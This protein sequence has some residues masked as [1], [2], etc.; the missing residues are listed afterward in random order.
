MSLNKQTCPIW[1]EP[2]HLRDILIAGQIRGTNRSG[3]EFLLKRDG[4]ALLQDLTERQKV[5]LSYWIY[6]YNFQH[7][8]INTYGNKEKL[9]WV[10][11]LLELDEAWV[12]D[13]RDCTPSALDRMLTWL[14]ELIR[15]DNAGE[16]ITR[17]LQMA[18][19][20]CRNSQ[21][22]DELVRHSMQQG[23]TGS[24]DPNFPSSRTDT[25]NLAGRLYVEERTRKLGQERQGFVARWFDCSMDPMH[26]EGIAPAIRDAGYKSRQIN[27]EGFTG[28]VVDEILAEI[29]KSKFVVADFT[30]CGKCTACKKCKHI[31]ARGGVYFEAGFALGL[32]KTVF[33]TCHKDRAEAVHFDV[34]HLNRIEWE[35]PEEL[36]EK[37]KNSIEA[38]LGH[39]PL[40]SSNGDQEVVGSHSSLAA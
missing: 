22:L 15:C 18:A 7:Q 37:L 17:E 31:G 19:G 27:D 29:R 10:N 3:G 36:R 20:G 16:E 14:Q 8:M 12:V 4:A 13:H 21:D 38:V 1:D 2:P 35:T 23:W 34:N 30:S 24:L 39:G 11:D 25:I 28:G 6:D 5:N 33:L 40:S 32:G 26:K 9:N